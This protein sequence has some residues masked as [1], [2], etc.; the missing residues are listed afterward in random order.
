M[1]DVC[2]PLSSRCNAAEPVSSSSS[3]WSSSMRYA[4]ALCGA[5][6]AVKAPRA[7][8]HVLLS[9]DRVLPGLLV[10]S[11]DGRLVAAAADA[12]TY[13][14]VMRVGDANSRGNT[15]QVLHTLPIEAPMRRAD[16]IRCVHHSTNTAAENSVG[17]SL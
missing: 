6:S 1:G 2:L 10:L 12:S 16:Y 4:A 9:G 17:G 3:S 7:V 15:M 14:A 13:I 5:I 11:P 8:Q